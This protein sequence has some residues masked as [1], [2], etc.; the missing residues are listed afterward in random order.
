MS[1]IIIIMSSS[2]NNLLLLLLLLLLYYYYVVLCGPKGCFTLVNSQ[3][4]HLL[5]QATQIETTIS[6]TNQQLFLLTLPTRKSTGE[7]TSTRTRTSLLIVVQRVLPSV[8]LGL[9][10]LPNKMVRRIA[11]YLIC[12]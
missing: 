10:L 8:S 12:Q 4:L 7:S 1:F 3:H 6:P 5:V 11:L 2:N 9:P